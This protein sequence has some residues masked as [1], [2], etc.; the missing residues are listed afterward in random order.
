[1]DRLNEVDSESANYWYVPRSQIEAESPS[2]HDGLTLDEEN[3]HRIECGITIQDI[4]NHLHLNQVTTATALVYNHRFYLRRSRKQTDKWVC[5]SISSFL[6][7]FWP[8][9]VYF[10]LVKL[11]KTVEK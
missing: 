3:F 6:F 1:M 4:A 11:K 8:Q 7:R 10:W 5:F 9:A 2:I